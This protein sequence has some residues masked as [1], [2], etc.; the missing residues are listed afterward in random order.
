MSYQSVNPYNGKTMQSFEEI[1]D[2]QLEE[3]IVKASACFEIWRKKSFSERA[4]IVAK[5]AAL[6]EERI[7]EFAKPVTIEMGKL[8]AQARG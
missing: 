1:D 6:M 4:T 3:A 8:I 2:K 5:A 7:E